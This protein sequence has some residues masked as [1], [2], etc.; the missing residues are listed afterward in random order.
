MRLLPLALAAVG[1]FALKWTG[2]WPLVAFA[3]I[4]AAVSLFAAGSLRALGHFLK[5]AGGLEGFGDESESRPEAVELGRWG[6]ALR[7]MTGPLER[8]P[9]RTARG[10]DFALFWAGGAAAL[11]A[12]PDHAAGAGWLAG[13]AGL[14]AAQLA[15]GRRRLGALLFCLAAAPAAAVSL[16]WVRP[17]EGLRIARTGSALLVMAA[18]ACVSGASVFALRWRI[19]ERVSVPPAAALA[20]WSLTWFFVRGEAYSRDPMIVAWGVG[21]GAVL[22]LA[23][24]AVR[25][26]DGAAAGVVLFLA[27]R[28]YA[29][30][31]WPA[32]VPFVAA[33]VLGWRPRL[34]REE[35]EGRRGAAYAL[36]LG[37]VP[38][39]LAGSYYVWNEAVL[40]GAYSA[41]CALHAATS[42]SLIL[43]RLPRTRVWVA[44][45]ACIA[46]PALPAGLG[47]YSG[48]GLRAAG[49][50]VVGAMLAWL[51]GE[52]LRS[53]S[54]EWREVPAPLRAGAL[55]VVA[56]GIAA[57]LAAFL[58]AGAVR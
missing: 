39:A 13:S 7:R 45:V 46:L 20:I 37:V 3:G 14:A 32:T 38:L 58:R 51:A 30:L 31:D 2:K 11:A 4:A 10:V 18:G 21:L 41:A 1:V 47:E 19:S 40:L 52:A 50:A 27:S 9:E 24:Y 25:A 57:G 17:D 8:L 44:V 26:L 55:G 5:K 43:T 15:P 34:R 53:A 6:S 12:F 35:A 22:A 54:R 28:V 16:L 29:F 23:G 36:V 48:Y 42:L 56:A 49:S 33:T